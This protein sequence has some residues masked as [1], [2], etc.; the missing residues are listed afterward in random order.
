M[1]RSSRMIISGVI[2]SGGEPTMQK[3]ALIALADGCHTMGLKVGVQ[4]NGV[5]PET[6][7]ALIERGLLDLVHMDI[8]TRWDHYPHLFRVGPEVTAH[9]RESLNLCMEANEDGRLKEFQVVV[10]LFPGREDDVYY[11]AKE[12]GD[13]DL[14]LNQGVEGSI[15]PLKFDEMKKIADKLR[16]PVKIRTRED[17]EVAYVDNRIIIA[18]SIVLTDILQARRKY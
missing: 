15:P 5:F 18:D 8:K 10:T 12:I 17:G 2:F 7:R 9:V 13:H 14:V 6:L 11:I 4:T 1:I 3:D 16:R